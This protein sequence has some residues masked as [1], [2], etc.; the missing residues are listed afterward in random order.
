MWIWVLAGVGGFKTDSIFCQIG[1]F[2]EF[3]AFFAQGHRSLSKL[4]FISHRLKIFVK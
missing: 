2:A 4:F 3:T 1:S